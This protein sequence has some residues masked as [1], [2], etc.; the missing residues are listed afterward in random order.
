M[1]TPSLSQPAQPK[2]LLLLEQKLRVEARTKTGADWFFWI[3]AL[4]MVNSISTLAG[5]DWGFVL[6]L[7]V[8][9][10]ADMLA[11]GPEPA[12]KIFALVVNATVAG[13]FVLFGL[14]ARQGLRWAF[15]AGMAVYA[16]DGLL[17]LV[18]GFW[19]GVAFHVLALLLIYNGLSAATRLRQLSRASSPA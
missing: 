12:G 19:L 15:L 8:T 6:G 4:S 3:A 11:L 16:A 7:G 18:S 5:S 10:V 9:Q 2:D 14:Y 13:I 1:G 17:W